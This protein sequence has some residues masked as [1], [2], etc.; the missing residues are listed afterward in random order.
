LQERYSYAIK[1]ARSMEFYPEKDM[2]GMSAAQFASNGRRAAK[3]EYHVLRDVKKC[4][5]T[6]T[7]FKFGRVAAAAAAAAETAA[8]ASSGAV[9]AASNGQQ[10]QTSQEEPTAPPPAAAAAAARPAA[11]L[12]CILLQYANGGSAWDVVYRQHGKPT[13]LSANDAWDVVAAAAFAVQDLHQAGYVHNDIKL[14]NML[15]FIDQVHGHAR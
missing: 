13:P 1:V 11:A 6:V 14:A 4:Y 12:P 5:Y 9:P 7:A 8:G 10:Q 3:H 2:K 15:R